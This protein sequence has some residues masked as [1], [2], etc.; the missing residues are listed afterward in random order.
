[1]FRPRALQVLLVLVGL[2]FTAAIYPVAMSL[3]HFSPSDDHGDTMMLSLYFTLGVFLLAAVR[4]PAAYRSVIA[5]AAWSS[6]AHGFTMTIMGFH[7]PAEKTELWIASAVLAGIGLALL[8]LLPP[9]AQ[10]GQPSTGPPS[11]ASF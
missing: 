4:K 5:F 8:A 1:M 11:P 7:L 2:L 10:V 6:F 9:K 3:W